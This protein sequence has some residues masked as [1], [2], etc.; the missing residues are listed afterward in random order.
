V[1][2]HGGCDIADFFVQFVFDSSPE[3]SFFPF[4]MSL[5]IIFLMFETRILINDGK[6]CCCEFSRIFL[7]FC[8]TE[9]KKKIKEKFSTLLM[10][11]F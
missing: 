3:F 8:V 11:E 7:I 5:L 1:R 6:I 2:L 9:K 10:N 4:P